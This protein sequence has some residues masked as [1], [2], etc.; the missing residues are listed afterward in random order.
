M[1]W[2]PCS[3]RDFLKYSNHDSNLSFDVFIINSY[4]NGLVTG[5]EGIKISGP[6]VKILVSA[7]EVCPIRVDSFLDDVWKF[8]V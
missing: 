3:L 5:D 7:P 8:S 2:Y 1:S 4:E 6:I